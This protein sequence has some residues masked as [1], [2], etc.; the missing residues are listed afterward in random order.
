VSWAKLSQAKSL[1]A[2]GPEHRREALTTEG[3][4][5]GLESHHLMLHRPRKTTAISKTLWRSFL[6]L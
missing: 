6:R 2:I 3:S 4:R 5:V 1:S